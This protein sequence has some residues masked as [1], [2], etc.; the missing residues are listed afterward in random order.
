MWLPISCNQIDKI[1]FTMTHR[2]HFLS[3]V[4]IV[5]AV[6]S[7][8]S[9]QYGYD[10]VYDEEYPAYA[11]VNK[12]DGSDKTDKSYNDAKGY[13]E[14]DYEYYG[15]NYGGNNSNQSYSSQL[16]RFYGPSISISYYSGLYN[17]HS[18]YGYNSYNYGHPSYGYGHNPFYY[19]PY[20]WHVNTYHGN[21]WGNPWNNYYYPPLNYGYG[22][23]NSHCPSA[24]NPYYYGGGSYE[25]ISYTPVH[26]G[27]RPNYAGA[28]GNAAQQNASS[29]IDND[30]N[31]VITFDNGVQV[32]SIKKD[33]YESQP[34]PS[35]NNAGNTN[36]TN[37]TTSPKPRSYTSPK[38]VY[39][40][41]KPR[42]NTKSVGTKT[43]TQPKPSYSQPKPRSSSSSSQSAGRPSDQSRSSG[44]NVKTY[45]KP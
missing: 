27:P 10:D 30:G 13:E 20:D 37:T 1:N 11:S 38:P 4:L 14:E 31:Q 19:D 21:F 16:D 5:F 17:P 9:V 7:C 33:N 32:R 26:Y 3:F 28:S 45:K 36:S 23:G 22:Y 34:R 40:Q 18:Y 6:A 15:R 24:Y 35:N 12:Y 41:P 44:V 8:T 43:Y 2:L 29:V 25:P 42:T 39:S